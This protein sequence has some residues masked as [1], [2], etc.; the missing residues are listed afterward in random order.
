MLLVQSC[1]F[2]CT[3][4]FDFL[5]ISACSNLWDLY[6]PVPATAGLIP[7][8]DR[9]GLVFESPVRSG[10]LASATKTGTET[11]PTKFKSCE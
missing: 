6:G 3:I 10:F 8:G 5:C 9:E 11:G 7:Y 2:F 1:S 4:Y